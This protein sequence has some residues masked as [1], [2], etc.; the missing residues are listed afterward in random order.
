MVVSNRYSFVIR[1]LFGIKQRKRSCRASL[2]LS[3]ALLKVQDSVYSD[4]SICLIPTPIH[5]VHRYV[6][7]VLSL[8]QHITITLC[9]QK[10]YNLNQTDTCLHKKEDQHN[11]APYLFA[12]TRYMYAVLY[13]ACRICPSFSG[14]VPIA[15][16]NVL[17]T[18]S[19]N[20]RVKLE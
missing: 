3:F 5:Q 20:T 11:T 6:Q 7:L 16:K 17:P 14:K 8:L 2:A 12:K 15:H 1:Y 9:C 19:Y 10:V 18:S 4:R 13:E